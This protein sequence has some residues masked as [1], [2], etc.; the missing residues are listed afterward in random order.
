MIITKPTPHVDSD[1]GFTTTTTQDIVNQHHSMN[2]V[3]TTTL[4]NIW[5]LI[6]PLLTNLQKDP[7]KDVLKWPNR[8]AAIGKLQLQLSILCNKTII[9]TIIQR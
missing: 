5:N 3:P 7:D 1:F 6:N 8:A 4:D 9:Q 2:G